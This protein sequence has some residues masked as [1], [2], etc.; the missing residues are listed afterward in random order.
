MGAEAP[1]M[2]EKTIPEI[3]IGKFDFVVKKKRA[4]HGAF[5]ESSDLVVSLAG[6]ESFAVFALLVPETGRLLCWR[7]CSIADGMRK[8]FQLP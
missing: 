6:S 7:C 3:K 8:I 1:A 4:R 5:A 2:S